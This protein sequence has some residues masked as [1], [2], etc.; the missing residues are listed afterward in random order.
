MNC[1][2]ARSEMQKALDLGN[3]QL[4]GEATQHAA[5]CNSCRTCWEQLCRLE[6]ALTTCVQDSPTVPADLHAGVLERLRH[7]GVAK[8]EIAGNRTGRWVLF[9]AA[10]MFVVALASALLFPSRQP[11]T[12][13]PETAS[14]QISPTSI[15]TQFLSNPIPDIAQTPP[16]HAIAQAGASAREFGMLVLSPASAA[17]RALQPENALSGPQSTPRTID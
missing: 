7:D 6:D 15:V 14:L 2:T 12:A 9:A 4:P 16:A 13:P 8:R 17:L 10:A 1:E 11:L 5:E 3:R